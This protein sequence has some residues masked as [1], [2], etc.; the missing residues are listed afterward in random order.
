MPKLI[1][2][3]TVPMALKHLL[4]GQMR[5][6]K[7]NG[8]DVIMVSAD[9]KERDDV[10]RNEECSHVIIPMTRQITPF[11]DLRSL[12][13]LYRFF[14][15]EKPD[16]VH[17]HTPK[18]GLLAMMAAKFSGVKIRIHTI[19]GLRFMTS[20]GFTRKILVMMEKLTAKSATHVWPNSFSLLKYIKENRLVNESKLQ[21]IAHGSSNGIYLKR[22]SIDRLDRNRVEEIKKQ[23]NYNNENIY[24]LSVGRIV[25]DKGINELLNVFSELYTTN[26]LLRLILVGSFE[27]DLDPITESAR[28][29]LK[30]HPGIIHI[31]WSNEVEYYMHLSALLVHPSHREGFPNVLLQAGAMNCPIVCSIIEGNIDIVDHQQTGLLFTVKNEA[32][33]KEKLKFATTNPELMKQ[34]ATR[35]RQKIETNFDQQIVHQAIREKYLQLLS[36]TNSGK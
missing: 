11:A 7:E 36:E 8:F 21:V 27:E 28:R 19:A 24:T 2:V 15:K 5:F 22:Y 25:N 14:K 26:E 33:L 13:Q 9:G 31:N 32:D 18:A 20:T 4:S 17:S 23:I 6:M 12:W 35:L 16:I 1:R 30:E 10:I 29:I 34:Y 3:T